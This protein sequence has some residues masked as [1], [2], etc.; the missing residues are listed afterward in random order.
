M[1]YKARV[2]L[3]SFTLHKQPL[4][5]PSSI[6]TTFH[7]NQPT[8]EMSNLALLISHG[9]RNPGPEESRQILASFHANATFNNREALQEWETHGTLGDDNDM[10][11]NWVS[12]GRTGR[13]F[14][15]IQ[16]DAREIARIYNNPDNPH[17]LRAVLRL[18]P[19]TCFTNQGPQTA[20]ILYT[21]D[22]YIVLWLAPFAPFGN[23]TA[24]SFVDPANGRATPRNK[25]PQHVP[26]PPNAYVYS[27]ILF[28][29]LG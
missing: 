21:S 28:T 8:T 26:R 13:V 9:F 19:A 7:D 15:F 23:L 11:L 29:L 20:D 18:Q 16:L 2:F 5:Q 27:N 25:P 24:G 4:P 1:L 10:I 22:G 6:T 14:R 3:L 12:M 17:G